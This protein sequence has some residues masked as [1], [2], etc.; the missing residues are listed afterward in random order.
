MHIFT[1]TMCMATAMAMNVFVCLLT[2]C[3]D[4]PRFIISPYSWYLYRMCCGCFNKN[5]YTTDWMN[6]SNHHHF[7]RTS[8]HCPMSKTACITGYFKW[9]FTILFFSFCF[10]YHSILFLTFFFSL[11]LSMESDIKKMVRFLN[12]GNI[13]LYLHGIFQIIIFCYSLFICLFYNFLFSV[14]F[15]YDL[16]EPQLKMM[17]HNWLPVESLQ[18]PF[19][20]R[21]L[22]VTS[23]YGN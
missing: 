9:V 15:F 19:I 2:V 20:S 14:F 8:F 23:N 11:S 7:Y 5:L 6:I 22:F 13:L 17:N 12:S 10:C 21:I 18:V 3:D 4:E 16:F 1:F